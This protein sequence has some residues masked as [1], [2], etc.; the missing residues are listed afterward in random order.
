MATTTSFSILFSSPYTL[1]ENI[2]FRA[3]YTGELLH[4]V[5][6]RV[7][8]YTAHQLV[9]GVQSQGQKERKVT[10][11]ISPDALQ[12]S[13]HCKS[14]EGTLC[15]HGYHALHELCWNSK[16]FFTIFEPGNLVSIALENKNIFHINY[17]SP[18]EFIVP[19]KSLGHLYD[20]KKIEST[21]LEQLSALASAAVPVRNT[22]LVW[23]L[24]YSNRP[25][26]NYLP[27]LVPVRGTSDKA[28]K[29]IKGFGK[30]FANINN[31]NLLSTPDQQQLYNLSEVMYVPLPKRHKF[32]PEDL[33]T[34]KMHIAE[35]FN[36]WE[37]ALPMLSQQPFVY[38]LRLAHPKYFMRSTPGRKYLERITL[39]TE[40][41]QLQF[42][43]KDKGNYYQLSLLYLVRGVPIKEPLEDALFFVCEDTQYY[44]LASLRDAAMVQWM[45][46]F[47]NLISVLKRGF[48]AFEKE[49]LERIETVYTV[50]RI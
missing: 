16:K 2:E 12:V 48:P 25:W 31:E 4:Y 23:L 6:N 41:P 15:A 1:D 44:L 27:I 14:P 35:N 3:F 20:F 39:S 26:Q 46:G 13:C 28:G 29:N 30:G 5:R 8:G 21:G 17:S 9:I 11:N 36:Q 24:V 45:S 32:E 40:R 7:I 49:I 22:E 19:D 42:F 47:E 18:G 10:F 50:V 34:G 37:R 43:L 33:L 38:K